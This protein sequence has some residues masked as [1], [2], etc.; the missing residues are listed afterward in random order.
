MVAHNDR[1]PKEQ[2]QRGG[3]K[4]HNEETQHLHQPQR[5][6]KRRFTSDQLAH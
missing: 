5:M 1:H 3:T 6:V 2:Q 4:G